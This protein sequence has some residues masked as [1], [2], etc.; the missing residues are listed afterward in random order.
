[1]N[2]ARWVQRAALAG[3]AG[4]SL[5]ALTPGVGA[6]AA[7]A[8]PQTFSASAGAS[9]VEYSF[10]RKPGL[11]QVSDTV[12]GAA[13]RA[14]STLGGGGVS[15]AQANS[16]FLGGVEGVP[17]LI[18]IA[19][20]DPQGN[21]PCSSIPPEGTFPPAFPFEAK[22][23]FPSHPVGDAT[24]HNNQTIGGGGAPLTAHAGITHAEAHELA[25]SAQAVSSSSTFVSGLVNTGS[26]RATTSQF[27]NTAGAVVSKAESLVNDIDIVKLIHIGSVHSATIVTYDGNRRPVTQTYT[28]VSDASVLGLP[29]TIDEKGIHV[30]GSSN[31]QVLKI[32]NEQLNYLLNSNYTTVQV[33]G[34]TT[35]PGEHSIRTQA[36]G[37]QLSFDDTVSGV[38]KP[39]PSKNIPY[40]TQLQDKFLQTP[41]GKALNPILSQV[42]VV[43]CTPPAP[44]DANARYFGTVQIAG[45]GDLVSA[46]SY[47][48]DTGVPP[49]GLGGLPGGSGTTTVVPGTAGTSGT[50]GTAGTPGTSPDVAPNQ[51]PQLA[52]SD[53]VGYVENLGDAAKK[54]KYLFP[55]FLL[56]VIGVL[57]GRIGKAPARL[58][59]AVS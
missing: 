44:P 21:S 34:A 36:G 19:A 58:P 11:S 46:A 6:Q 56:A 54:L 47:S 2:G 17:G 29:A 18:C 30:G 51:N 55:A 5:W 35:E 9:G 49:D 38:P 27:I 31:A 8:P 13:P 37:L 33:I 45:V 23:E 7:A 59:R 16:V 43:L 14:S 24:F 22:A 52:G 41:L 48:F 12:H 1:M 57:A 26:A 25:A 39:P 50:P 15:V 3:A 42:P 40:C 53:G 10:D 28:K 32:L 20:A 4:L